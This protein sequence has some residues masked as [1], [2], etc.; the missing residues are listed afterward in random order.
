MCLPILSECWQKSCALCQIPVPVLTPS[1]LLTLWVFSL[2]LMIEGWREALRKQK[3]G[4]PAV[5]RQAR[6]LSL[7]LLDPLRSLS[8]LP[9]FHCRAAL[10]ES[11][12]EVVKTFVLLNTGYLAM[13]VV[14]PLE[15][16]TRLF[17]LALL[18]PNP[19]Q[20]Y[21]DPTHKHFETQMYKSLFCGFPSQLAEVPSTSLSDPD[22]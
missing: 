20:P 10:L 13:S 12:S 5:G 15:Q 9:V 2:E 16:P 21:W 19:D 8:S 3:L 7:Y 18:L 11:S 22:M 1:P 6:G 17:Y 14:L 4:R